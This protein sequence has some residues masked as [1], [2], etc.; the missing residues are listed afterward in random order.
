MCPVRIRIRCCLNE[1][2]EMKLAALMPKQHK[3][4]LHWYAKYELDRDTYLCRDLKLSQLRRRLVGGQSLLRRKRQE[5]RLRQ[6]LIQAFGRPTLPW[7]ED[8]EEFKR[9]E[10]TE[11]DLNAIQ[12]SHFSHLLQENFEGKNR[13]A[14]TAF[15]P[16]I[17]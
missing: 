4:V 9:L 11:A 14:S 10:T 6:L 16:P 12:L 13:N 5:I 17:F 8:I 15:L 7:R 1:L 2:F 3:G